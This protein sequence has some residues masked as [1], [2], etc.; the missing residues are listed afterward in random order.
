MAEDTKSPEALLIEARE[1]FQRCHDAENENRKTALDDIRFARL[2]DQWP[3]EVKKQRMVDQRPMLTINKLP[4]FIRQVV[5]DSRQNKP[6][7]KVNPVDSNADIKTAD[8]LSGIIRNI[9]AVSNADVAYDTAVEQAVSSGFGY[10]RVTLDYAYDESFDLDI[11]IKRITNQFSVYADPNSTEADSS[12]WDVCFVTDRI[13]KKVY[14]RKYKD[15][16]T[17][18]WD[19]QGWK[20]IGNDW[21]NDDGVLIAEWWRRYDVEREVVLLDDGRTFDAEEFDNDP[22]LQTAKEAEQIIEVKRRK[23]SSKRVTQTIISGA[24]VLEEEKEFPG[25]YIPIVPVYGDEIL[26]E[27]KR[28]FRSLINPAKDAQMA[29][30]FWRSAAAEL[31]ALAPRVPWIGTAETFAEDERWA[32]ANTASHSYLVFG[33]SVPPQRLPLDSGPAAGVLQ[34]AMN[35]ND[36]IKSSIGM[37]DASLGARSN[38][39]SGKAIL[40]RQREGDVATFHFID[41]VTRAIRHTG[42]ILIG[43]IPKV[44][45]GERIMRVLGEDGEAKNIPVNKPYQADDKGNPVQPPQMGHNGGPPMPMDG[46][47]PPMTQPEQNE[48]PESAEVAQMGSVIMAMHDLSI[49]KYDVTVT[50]GP[51]F[52]TRR[53]EAA[54]EQLQFLQAFPQAAPIIGDI[55]AKNLDWPGA[56]EIADRLAEAMGHSDKPQ[57][58]PEVQQQIE[59]GQQLIEQQKSEIE[60]L[61]ADQ[62]VQQAQTQVD[63]QKIQIDAKRTEIEGQKAQTAQY[64]A[65]TERMKMQ[66]DMQRTQAMMAAGMPMRPAA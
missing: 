50:S 54:A 63:M 5:N 17:V 41:N 28:Y 52:T 24:D 32:T 4:A 13:P 53:A 57:I 48:A 2:G 55:V 31:V 9:E 39:T 7:I 1:A 14:E 3:S 15:K 65:E 11:M 38:E 29:F 64:E 19:S 36:D 46:Q 26:I 34:E 59:Q 37:F 12:D 35:A 51:S 62:S 33:G 30:N 20:D 47:Q 22:D 10:W 58:P 44:Y 60:Q 49:G 21:L 8:V 25:C 6:S 45:T 42:K 66:I 56:Q 40:A 43:L 23:I 18:D 61:K 16:A 27:G